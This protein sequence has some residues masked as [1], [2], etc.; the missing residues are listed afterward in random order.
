MLSKQECEARALHQQS[1]GIYL[2]VSTEKPYQTMSSINGFVR[3]SPQEHLTIDR[4]RFENP[5]PNM[6]FYSYSTKNSKKIN[7]APRIVSIYVS[8]H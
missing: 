8:W 2:N 4:D 1:Y 7:R 5:G 3:A 6:N